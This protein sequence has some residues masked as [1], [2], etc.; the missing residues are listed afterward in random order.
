MNINITE[1]ISRDKT[2]QWK[3][4]RLSL[5]VK[6]EHIEKYLEKALLQQQLQAISQRVQMNACL[7]QEDYQ[8]WQDV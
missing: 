2:L 1:N 4:K 6:D 3:V 7:I 8:I 5:H